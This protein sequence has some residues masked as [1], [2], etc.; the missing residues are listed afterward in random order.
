MKSYIGYCEFCSRFL[1]RMATVTRQY[2][3]ILSKLCLQKF[4]HE[5]N[6]QGNVKKRDI[7]I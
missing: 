4:I 1:D 3:R 6:F 2:F 5:I 7:D